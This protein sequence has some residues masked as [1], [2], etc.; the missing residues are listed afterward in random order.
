MNKPTIDINNKDDI[1]RLKV[2]AY[3]LRLLVAKM[4]DYHLLG[5]VGALYEEKTPE[6]FRL[7][8][9]DALTLANDALEQ[10]GMPEIEITFKTE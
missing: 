10:L 1:N 7:R 5:E 9:L 4:E 8:I 6:E 2:L 3:E